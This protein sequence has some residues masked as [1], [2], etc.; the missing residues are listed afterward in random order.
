MKEDYT[1]APVEN[2]QIAMLDYS[3][4]LTKEPNKVSDEDVAKLKNVGLTDREILDIC[5]VTA[6]FNFVNRMAEG[7]G[8]EL[9]PE[10]Q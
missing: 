10:Y 3:V 1:K 5:Q 6:Y 9:E 4:K 2:K 8:V 7:L